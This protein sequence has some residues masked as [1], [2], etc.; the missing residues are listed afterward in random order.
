MDMVMVTGYGFDCPDF[1]GSAYEW[2]PLCQ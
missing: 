1:V 2:T